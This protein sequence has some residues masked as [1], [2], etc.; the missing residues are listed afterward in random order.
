MK[1]SNKVSTV[2]GAVVIAVSVVTVWASIARADGNDGT[3]VL[4]GHRVRPVLVCPPTSEGRVTLPDGSKA[5]VRPLDSDAHAS[6]VEC[7]VV[8]QPVSSS[9]R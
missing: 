2:L 3:M 1:S 6:V 7:K 4:N 9:V 5:G 8:Y